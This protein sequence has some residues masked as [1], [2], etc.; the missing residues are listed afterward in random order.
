MPLV[1]SDPHT[2]HLTCQVDPYR[3]GWTLERFLSHRFRY[4]PAP[5]WRERMAAG[6]VRLN[7][8]TAGP[9][10]LVRKGDRIEYT[11]V[12]AEPAVDFRYS[13]LHDDEH[14]LAVAKSGNLPVHA[15]G[16]YI[17]NTLIARLREDFGEGLR[18]A[19]RLDRETSGVIVLARSRRAAAA[20]ERQFRGRRVEKR[21]LAVVRGTAPE[22]LT[23]DAAIVR[24]EPAE[25][26]Y[27]RAA[28]APG[29]GG[30]AAVTR[31][32]R[33]R[34]GR[35]AAP[36]HVALSLVEAVPESGRTN[37]I[38]V[39]A[40][41]AGFPILGD[42]VYG[43]PEAIARAFVASGPTEEIEAIAG[44]PRHLLH[45]AELVLAHP[46]TGAPLRLSAPPP[47]DFAAAWRDGG[48][49]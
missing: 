23:V 10:A 41:H 40:A 1:K 15:G 3:D 30:K 35:A 8:V 17:R 22:E 32:R 5:I 44:A 28:V 2:Y 45:C 14:V 34:L 9:D 26:P 46:E 13:V 38:R 33:L 42:K 43:V 31:F 20:F 7:G 4:H 27:F 47:D 39:H 12:H 48:A 25:P 36:P 37:Q 18:P 24:R 29:D 21:Y 19:H 49:G 6:D 11:V 16:K